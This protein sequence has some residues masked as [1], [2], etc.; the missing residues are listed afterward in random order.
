MGVKG[1]KSF[2]GKKTVMSEIRRAEETKVYIFI[3][4]NLIL[5]HTN[6][7][8]EQKKIAGLLGAVSTAEIIKRKGEVDLKAKS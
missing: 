8:I 1:D 3:Y 5:Q 7:R 2:V 4:I 6:T